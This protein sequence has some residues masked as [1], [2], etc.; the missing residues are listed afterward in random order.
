MG[1][2]GSTRITVMVATAQSPPLARASGRV[3]NVAHEPLLGRPAMSTCLWRW[4]PGRPRL[5]RQ[6][7]LY[8][9]R[10]PVTCPGC[11]NRMPSTKC[12]NEYYVNTVSFVYLSG[13]VVLS[14][15]QM[16]RGPIW[17]DD[18]IRL[19]SHMDLT[20]VQRRRLWSPMLKETARW[21]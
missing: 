7:P 15:L 9:S 20:G 6:L 3:C 1:G 19:V 10:Q 12:P 11:L 5:L 2:F 14:A 16:A 8:R 13:Y 17:L 4:V 18:E 21:M